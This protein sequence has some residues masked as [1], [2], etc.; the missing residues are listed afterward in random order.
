MNLLALGAIS[1]TS[2]TDKAGPPPVSQKSP[3]KPGAFDH[4]L[5]AGN[6]AAAATDSPSSGPA[7][8]STAPDT[9]AAEAT[10]D[11]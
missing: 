8:K 10:P 3:G 9:P 1:P 5:R 11:P 7:A 2:G 4:L 6:A